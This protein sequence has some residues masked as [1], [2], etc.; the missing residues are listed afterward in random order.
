MDS[1]SVSCA[2]ELHPLRAG[3]PNDPP[4]STISRTKGVVLFRLFFV[5]V[6]CLIAA[7]C[8]SVEYQPQTELFRGK[9]PIGFIEDIEVVRSESAADRPNIKYWMSFDR[10]RHDWQQALRASLDESGLSSPSGEP[11]RLV[12]TITASDMNQFSVPSSNVRMDARYDLY[13]R[14]GDVP[15]YS[16]QS[17][18]QTRESFAPVVGGGIFQAISGA[19]RSNIANFLVNLDTADRSLFSGMASTDSSYWHARLDQQQSAP[20]S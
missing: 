20:Q 15:I 3:D 6:F 17:S 4:L 1:P 5:L 14:N 18:S 19:I 9:A 10:Y 8:A 12:V 11:L 13:R 16:F 7:S 2:R